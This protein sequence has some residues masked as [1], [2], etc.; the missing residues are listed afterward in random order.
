[1]QYL[2]TR[3]V[4]TAVLAAAGMTGSRSF[5]MGQTQG[6]P[7]AS[8]P[9]LVP[10]ARSSPPDTKPKTRPAVPADTIKTPAQLPPSSQTPP[11][12]SPK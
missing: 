8:D 10:S 11:P 1:M 5:A 3:R 6:P 2:P 12:G 7:P 4:V 9:Q